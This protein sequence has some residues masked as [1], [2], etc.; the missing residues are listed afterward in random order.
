LIWADGRA[1]ATLHPE[2]PAV[3]AASETVNNTFAF[4]PDSQIRAKFQVWSKHTIILTFGR[5]P[6]KIRHISRSST[7]YRTGRSPK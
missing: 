3:I 2:P 5:F 1:T 6:S 4:M 7:G